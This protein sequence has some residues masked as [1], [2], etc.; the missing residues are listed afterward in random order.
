LT[1]GVDWKAGFIRTNNATTLTIIANENTGAWTTAPDTNYKYVILNPHT[2][3]ADGTDTIYAGIDAA[4]FRLT[5]AT[6]TGIS[7]S[8]GK[9][10]ADPAFTSTTAGSENFLPAAESPAIDAGT[11]YNPASDD[12]VGT[13]RPQNT[14]YDI[15]AYEVEVTQASTKPH[16]RFGFGFDFKR[17]N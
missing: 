14:L 8:A 12:I 4:T 13:S 15:G 9:V 1:N 7:I 17:L 3:L 2:V 11:S 5:S 6:D 10:A 16:R